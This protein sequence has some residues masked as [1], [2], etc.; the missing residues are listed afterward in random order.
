M[1]DAQFRVANPD[2]ELRKGEGGR[3]KGMRKTLL[4]TLLRYF[5]GQKKRSATVYTSEVQ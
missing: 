3:G 4:Q 5:V 2:L 1:T